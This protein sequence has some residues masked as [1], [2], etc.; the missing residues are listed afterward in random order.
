[1]KNLLHFLNDL[2]SSVLQHIDAVFRFA[3]LFFRCC[4]NGFSSFCEASQKSHN[5]YL[6]RT[7]LC[8]VYVAVFN[9]KLNYGKSFAIHVNQNPKNE[10]N[11]VSCTNIYITFEIKLSDE[12]VITKY[13][14]KCRREWDIFYVALL[15]ASPIHN[16]I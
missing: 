4:H 11:W 8:T 3:W 1:M 15:C 16:E 12:N 14:L 13:F 10:V 2:F 6:Q 7:L 9:T 5:I